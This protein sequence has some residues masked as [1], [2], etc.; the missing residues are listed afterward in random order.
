MS[1]RLRFEILKRDNFT[2]R[3]C[4]RKP[5][6]VILQ[7]DHILAVR[8]GGLN[9]PENLVTACKECN[10]G[11]SAV[12][13][14]DVMKETLPNVEMERE[15]MAKL[16]EYNKVISEQNEKLEDL[17]YQV[18]DLWIELD[19]NDPEKLEI[20]GKRGSAVRR[21]L[22]ELPVAE[23]LDALRITARN[24]PEWFATGYQ[25]AIERYFYAVCNRK[26]ESIKT[27]KPVSLSPSKSYPGR[28]WNRMGDLES[29]PASETL[30]L[31][32]GGAPA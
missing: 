3:Y 7:V 22:R 14:Q 18:S 15:R 2:C 30:E 29:L 17:F 21:I 19:G 4:G 26:L 9:I 24:K 31:P 28:Q 23:V 16:E 1:V 11:K 25:S 13:L 20:C 10:A 32:A 12:P 6:G 8:D 5:P 27:S